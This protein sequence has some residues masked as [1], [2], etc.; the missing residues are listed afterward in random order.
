M[1][2][3]MLDFSPTDKFIVKTQEIYFL[4]MGE[5]MQIMY[6]MEVLS[7][8]MPHL[9]PFGWTLKYLWVQENSD[10]EG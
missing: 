3:K 4:V 8:M 5:R 10:W 9:E 6:S 2:K 7:T 1:A